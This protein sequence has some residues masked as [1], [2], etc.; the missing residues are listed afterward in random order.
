MA[1]PISS[2]LRQP[3]YFNNKL[4]Y[5]KLYSFDSW[6]DDWNGSSV[7]EI[8]MLPSSDVTG[9]GKDLST[10]DTTGRMCN[11]SR[12]STQTGALHE[13]QYVWNDE[14]GNSSDQT[15]DFNEMADGLFVA[16]TNDW[17]GTLVRSHSRIGRSARFVCVAWNLRTFLRWVTV[18]AILVLIGAGHEELMPFYPKEIVVNRKKR[19]S[20]PPPVRLMNTNPSSFRFEMTTL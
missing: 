7:G 12:K 1:D 2:E 15:G 20:L 9:S 4:S 6:D 5:K 17:R 16:Q 19:G 3:A 13:T 18:V 11:K 14:N 10:H 8:D